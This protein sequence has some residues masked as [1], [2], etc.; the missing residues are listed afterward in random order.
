MI[1]PRGHLLEEI[2]HSIKMLDNKINTTAFHPINKHLSNLFLP[3]D[4]YKLDENILISL[5]QRNI[6]PTDSNKKN[7]SYVIKNLR[8]PT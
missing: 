5:I 1:T 8:H 2:K 7:L 6:L 4:N 3:H